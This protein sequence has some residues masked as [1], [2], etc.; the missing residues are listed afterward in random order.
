MLDGLLLVLVGYLFD[1]SA[2]SRV[3]TSIVKRSILQKKEVAA[4]RVRA[5]R[6]LTHAKTRENK[7]LTSYVTVLIPAERIIRRWLLAQIMCIPT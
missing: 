1:S 6:L 2:H 3:F 4:I 5:S 7:V